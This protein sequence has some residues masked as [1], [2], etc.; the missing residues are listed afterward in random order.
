MLQ[1]ILNA[2]DAALGNDGDGVRM[3]GPSTLRNSLISGNRVGV[4]VMADNC[5]I[6]NN[7]IGTDHLGQNSLANQQSGLEL[8]LTS[9]SNPLTINGNTIS[10]NLNNG[11]LITSNT[12]LAAISNNRIGVNA[13]DEALPNQHHGVLIEGT[14]GDNHL[15]DNIIAHNLLDGVRV[16]SGLNQLNRNNIF[17]NGPSNN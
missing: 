11:I 13:L 12:S 5:T 7:L 2:E 17:D 14:S 9:S 4:L 8:R 6:E 3:L 15:Q 16:M 1:D 10:G